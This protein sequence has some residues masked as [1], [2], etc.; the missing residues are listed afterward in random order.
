MHQGLHLRTSVSPQV[1]EQ[2]ANRCC[3]YYELRRRNGDANTR[4]KASVNRRTDAADTGRNNK[5][6]L[7]LRVITQLPRRTDYVCD[8]RSDRQRV[9]LRLKKLPAENICDRYK[10]PSELTDSDNLALPEHFRLAS[11][12]LGAVFEGGDL[13]AACRDHY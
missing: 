2:Q 4:W 9:E 6:E 11:H 10:T 5:F 12:G 7:H 3:Q 1:V 8:D 13:F